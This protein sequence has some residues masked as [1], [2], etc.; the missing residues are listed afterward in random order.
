MNKILSILLAMFVCMNLAA[1]PVN[2]Y[3]SGT[4]TGKVTDHVDGS[5]IAGATVY[6]PEPEVG[7]TTDANGVYPLTSLPV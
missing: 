6:L 3:K 4:L 7:V 2:N 1:V 5:T